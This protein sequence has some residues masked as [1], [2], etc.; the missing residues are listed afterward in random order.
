MKLQKQKSGFLDAMMPPMAAS[1]IAPMTSSLIQPVSFSL[2]N[3]I[4]G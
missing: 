4:S 2:I 3:A 1:F